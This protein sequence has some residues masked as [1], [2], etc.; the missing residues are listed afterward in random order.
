MTT[1]LSP[2]QKMVHRETAKNFQEPQTKLLNQPNRRKRVKDSLYQLKQMLLNCDPELLTRRRNGP[3]R[4][5][6]EEMD[7][8][9]MAV[10]HW[11]QLKTKIET[12]GSSD[13]P[14]NMEN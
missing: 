6:L 10:D 11:K 5:Q 9:E 7:L 14:F 3:R 1:E 4:G 12:S 13:S 8:L 2:G